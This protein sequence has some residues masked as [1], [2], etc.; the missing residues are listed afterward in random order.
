MSGNPL[1]LPLQD[2][3]ARPRR[4]GFENRPDP[5]EGQVTDSWQQ[6]FTALSTTVS[7][8]PTLITKVSLTG[9]GAAI[10][11]TDLS[12]GSQSTGLFRITYYARITTA[13]GVS[14]SLTVTIG[15]TETGSAL[16]LS[17]TAMTG[18]T[19]TTTQSGTVMVYAD[20]ATPITYATAYASNAAGVMRYRLS[21]ILENIAA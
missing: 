15:W 17:G 11:A 20:S 18:N 6:V 12:G 21:V 14:S 10:A 4:A 19:T 8:Q 2:P 9:Q 16:T 13:A 1:L 3:I 5:L 7:Q